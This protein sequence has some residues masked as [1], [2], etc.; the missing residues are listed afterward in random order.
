M[1]RVKCTNGEC[2]FNNYNGKC[3]KN[4]IKLDYNGCESFEKNI[5]YYI[6]LVWDKLDSSNMIL[7]LDMTHDLMIG[8]Y[9]VTELYGLEFH[10][11][12]WGNDSFFVF[13]KNG[14]KNGSPLSYN[15]IISIDMNLEKLRYHVEK[16][17]QGILPPYEED[18]KK[19]KETEIIK[20]KVDSQPFGWLSP[21]GEFIESDWGTHEKAAQN[22]VKK[23]GFEE[24]YKK[25]NKY[26]EEKYKNINSKRIA[27]HRDFLVEAKGYVLIHNPSLIGNYIVTYKKDLTKKQKEFLY[28]YFIDM[29]D[30]LNAERYFND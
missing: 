6:H 3:T 4:T 29:G 18:K 14:V 7:P 10:G 13:S 26:Q 27:L 2:K 30:S 12:I 17:N 22:I 20:P 28:G 24:E 16:F 21:T 25:W 5:I 11:V 1:P 9:Y 19:P 23:K 8:I 15:D